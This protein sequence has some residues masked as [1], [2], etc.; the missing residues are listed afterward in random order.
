MRGGI[1]ADEMGL[2]KTIMIS[3]LIQTN[4]PGSEAAGSQSGE[5]NDSAND[6]D[7]ARK[8]PRN[9]QLRLVSSAAQQ[10]KGN[11]SPRS[12]ATL[13][14]APTSL[15]NQWRDELVRSSGG[16]LSVLVY[17]DQKD[18]ISFLDM[19]DEGVDV[20]LASFGKVGAEWA[21]MTG[22]E[23]D[24]FKKLPKEG[25]YAVDWYR[26]IL[27]EVGQGLSMHRPAWLTIHA[28]P[29]TSSRAARE[30]PKLAMPSEESAD[31]A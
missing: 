18:A 23:S 29:T 14:V 2:G 5:E 11:R 4:V 13:V 17:N 31:G 7:G 19:L 16:L 26:V 21:K 25:I 30:Q 1:L 22:E 6:S 12:S 24:L 3:A 9:R 28:R 8:A 10:S 20:V 15:L 27:D